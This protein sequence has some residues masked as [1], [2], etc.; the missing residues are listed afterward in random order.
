MIHFPSPQIEFEGF[1]SEGDTMDLPIDKQFVITWPQPLDSQ[2]N[3]ATV[4]PGS[5]VHRISDPSKAA[6]YPD[7]QNPYSA[8]VR[9]TTPAPDIDVIIEADA[10]L[11]AGVTLIT[12][13]FR[14]NVT[15]GQAVGFGAPTIGPVGP[16]E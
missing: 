10:D 1:I 9:G 5:I 11:G 4:Q 8:R 13:S 14:F 3:P 7:A 12:N 2:G 16:Q 15:S 6:V